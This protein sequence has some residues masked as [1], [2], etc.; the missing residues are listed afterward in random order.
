M[1]TI[2]RDAMTACLVPAL[3]FAGILGCLSAWAQDT[4]KGRTEFIANCAACHG[5]DGKGSGP[6]AADLKVKPADLTA[7]AKRTNG[8]FNP[9]AVYQMI[10]GRD[11]RSAHRSADMPIWGCRHRDGSTAQGFAKLS[12]NRKHKHRFSVRSGRNDLDS[13]LDLP[14]DP[15]SVIQERILSIVGYLSLIQKK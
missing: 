8:R 13:L 1:D 10:D 4:D 6:H 3:A 2:R 14:C 15:D 5:A 11:G 12:I 9:S 7:L